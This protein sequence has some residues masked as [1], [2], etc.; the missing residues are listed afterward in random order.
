MQRQDFYNYVREHV[1]PGHLSQGQ[2]DGMEV[3][4][5]RGEKQGADPRF[6]AYVLATAFHETDHTMQPVREIGLGRGRPYGNPD[7]LPNGHIY[8]GRGYVQLTWRTNYQLMGERLGIAL[9]D[10]P[11]R[12]LDPPI[13]AEIIYLGMTDGTF[14]GKKL[15]DYFNADTSDWYNARRIVN[16]LDRA[17]LIAGYGLGF[18][19]AMLVAD[20]ET[21]RTRSSMAAFRLLPIDPKTDY[22]ALE[23]Q[24]LLAN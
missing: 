22:V 6:V 9:A 12:A 17:Q 14:T 20:G 1:F 4:L 19:R 21:Q 11:D 8:Y 16:G 13:A 18:Y 23:R 2:V 5:D 15:A 10:D 3:L 7:P 24:S